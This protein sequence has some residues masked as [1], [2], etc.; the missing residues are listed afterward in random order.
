[1]GMGSTRCRARS[2]R[3]RNHA[4]ALATGTSEGAGKARRARRGRAVGAR[5]GRRRGAHGSP[6]LEGGAR[7]DLGEVLAL[8]GRAQ[9]AAEAV[10]QALVRFEAKEDVVMAEGMRG[11]LRARRGGGG[12]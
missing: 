3:R 12:G 2:A 5:G 6:R 11:R 9:E 4:D 1:R 8:A 10:E 7:A